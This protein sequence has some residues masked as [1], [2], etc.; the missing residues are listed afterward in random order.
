MLCPQ[1]RPSSPQKYSR[2]HGFVVRLEAA[3][4]P[5][6]GSCT[7]WVV[8]RLAQQYSWPHAPA[9]CP[10]CCSSRHASTGHQ[11]LV[12]CLLQVTMGEAS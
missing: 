7:E 9:S 5:V 3:L 11:R 2:T 12:L 10:W 4:F 6:S 8:V 1:T